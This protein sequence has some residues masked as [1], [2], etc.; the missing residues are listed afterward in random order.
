[1]SI[2]GGA[3]TLALVIAAATLCKLGD[4][5]SHRHGGAIG[6]SHTTNARVCCAGGAVAGR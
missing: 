5:S 1:M 4:T 6:R 2:R 3:Y